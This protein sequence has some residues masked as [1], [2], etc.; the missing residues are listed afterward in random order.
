MFTF[1]QHPTTLILT[2]VQLAGQKDDQR[3]ETEQRS[4]KIHQS[5]KM[6]C[7]NDTIASALEDNDADRD[8][9]VP[10]YCC[11]LLCSTVKR[12]R[13]HAYV[14]STPDPITRLRQHNGELTQGAKKTSKKRPWKIIMLVYGFPTKLAALQF[15]WAWQNPTRSRQFEKA[16]I[17]S[18]QSIPTTSIPTVPPS[19]S[20]GKRRRTLRPIPTVFE[21]LQTVHTMVG[22]PSWIR[23][24]LTVYIMDQELMLQWQELDKTQ[25]K[26]GALGMNTRILVKLGTIDQLAPYFSDRGFRQEQLRLNELEKFD[27]FKETDSRCL[28]CSRNIDYK[29][30]TSF[31]SCNNSKSP[32]ECEMLAHLDCMS[33]VL[34]A[35]DNRF[36]QH[37]RMSLSTSSQHPQQNL[38]PTGGKC[39]VCQGEMSW[40]AM[41]HAMNARVQAIDAREQKLQK[42]RAKSKRETSPTEVELTDPFDSP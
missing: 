21:K 40:A 6:D 15:E 9:L 42:K 1:S 34:L 37:I 24:P 39:L 11:Y 30:P 8:P 4:I 32:K 18:Q 2:K 12:Y 28:V 13:T 5:V 35:K 41:I 17:A 14:G 22:R 33:T 7:N 19:P 20:L 10:F 3:I 36:T 38:L 16:P 23:W 25:K 26:P 29:D 27:R 31:L